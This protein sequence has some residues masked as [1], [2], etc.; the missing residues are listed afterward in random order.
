MLAVSLNGLTRL[1]WLSIPVNRLA[2]LCTLARLHLAVALRYLGSLRGLRR[3]GVALRLL[4][5][6][7]LPVTLGDLAVTLHRLA[8]TLGYLSVALRRLGRLTKLVGL[9]K[10]AKLAGL[11][12]L[13]GAGLSGLVGRSKVRH[14][15]VA[16]SILILRASR[17][18]SLRA[19]LGVTLSGSRGTS[20]STGRSTSLGSSRATSLRGT[21][22]DAC[23]CLCLCLCLW[24]RLGE[25]G[26]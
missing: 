9:A 21:L 16:G 15:P 23:L 24:L 10:L 5:R 7:C 11:T 13:S 12:G 22:C 14:R 3:L 20:V 1:N 26:V 2:R 19:S 17:G 25:V 6:L 8:I 4:R 18:T